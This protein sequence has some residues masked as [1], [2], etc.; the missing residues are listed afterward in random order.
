MSSI[1]ISY[2]LTAKWDIVYIQ[3]LPTVNRKALC[4][5]LK[6]CVQSRRSAEWLEADWE[7]C[8]EIYSWEGIVLSNAREQ[9]V[10]SSYFTF[11]L[12][13][14]CII[15][16]QGIYT[17]GTWGEKSQ[18]IHFAD[19]KFHITHYFLKQEN[20]KDDGQDVLEEGT[21][22]VVIVVGKSGH[23]KEH[24]QTSEV[25][26]ASV[27]LFNLLILILC[28]DS[29][30]LAMQDLLCM[31][32]DFPPRAHCLVRWWVLFSHPLYSLLA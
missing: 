6:V 4:I 28:P 7:L 8:R 21:V 9:Y 29:F 2:T 24:T 11:C 14:R 16:T 26:L 1:K 22:I 32:N 12:W 18:D 5:Y 13:W 31:N 10:A 27:I 30:P 15:L 20:E 23:V 19:F 25:N 3:L 17:S